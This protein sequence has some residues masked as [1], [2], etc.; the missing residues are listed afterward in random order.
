[1]DP[2]AVKE[3]T[4]GDGVNLGPVCTERFT[5]YTAIQCGEAPDP[6]GWTEVVDV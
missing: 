4:Y 5:K 6:F 2:V 3:F 1:V